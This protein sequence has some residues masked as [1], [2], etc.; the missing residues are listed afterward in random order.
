MAVD[1]YLD[2][3]LVSGPLV[4]HQSKRSRMREAYQSPEIREIGSLEALTA[5]QFNKV[6]PTPDTLTAINPNVVGSFVPRP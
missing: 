4:V 3:A 1:S 6:G 2:G 5:Q